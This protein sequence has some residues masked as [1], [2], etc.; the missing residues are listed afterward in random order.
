MLFD[1]KQVM[2]F[3]PHRDPFLFVD[4]VESIVNDKWKWGQGVLADNRDT[5]GT[6]ITAKYFTRPDLE[7]FK[8]HFPGHP[9]FPGV[10]Q[11]EMMAQASSF[12]IVLNHADP[13]GPT[14]SE[15]ALASVS[16]AK[17]RRPI[18]PNMDLTIKATCNRYRGQIMGCDC[19]V[20]HNG[21]LMSEASV[22]ASVKF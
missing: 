10:V 9:I 11:V 8:G 5:L 12:V 18:L 21:D 20:F 19:Q 13:F 6:V 15:M 14:H 3:L 4:S 7:I 2:A 1:L 17:F 22:L 16:N